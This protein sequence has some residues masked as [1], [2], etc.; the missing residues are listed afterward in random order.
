MTNLSTET[1]TENIPGTPK[2]FEISDWVV[3]FFALFSGLVTIVFFV[4]GLA[5]GSWQ[6]IVLAGI[7]VLIG[8]ISLIAQLQLPRISNE[9]KIL[10]LA[11][12][13]EIAFIVTANF[14]AQSW[15]PLAIVS[16]VFAILVSSVGLKGRL[17]NIGLIAGL[18]SALI[19][20]L[21]GNFNTASQISS[22]AAIIFFYTI[23]AILLGIYVVLILTRQALV[24]LRIK[25]VTIF[26]AITLI[27]LI[28]I[29]IIQSI[30][31]QN[32]I[33][34]QA[35]T[36][37]RLA[38]QQVAAEID[39]FFNSNVDSISKEASLKV[40]PN[41]INLPSADRA[42]SQ[43]ETDLNSTV[44]SL[45]IKSTGFT[46]SYGILNP[47]GV[48]IYDTN[49]LQIGA[50]EGNADYFLQ[51]TLTGLAYASPVE[52]NP[53]N[54]DSYIYFSA[55]IRNE[56]LNVIGV[57]RIRYDAL[58]LQS[59]LKKYISL[60]GQRSYPILLDEYFIRLGDAMTPSLLYKSITPLN[61]TQISNL[62]VSRR[63]PS[64]T[65][66]Q[67]ST[68]LPELEVALRDAITNPYFVAEL[69]PND[70]NHKE[71]GAIIR[72]TSQPWYL[73]FVEEQSIIDQVRVQQLRTSS[74]IATLIAG[75]IGIIGMVVSTF[76]SNPIL[77]LTSVAEKI[78]GG[79]MEA[80]AVIHTRDEIETLG[81]TFN[82]M[83][84]QLKGFIT[85]LEDRVRDRTKQLAEQ[86][87]RL[88]FRSRQLQ[89]V[90][91]VARGIAQTQALETLL[92]T[93]V[94]L[95]SNR[96][97]FYHVGI[98]LLDNQKQYA[99]LRAANS[100]GGK[101]MLARQHR[102]EVG[103]VGIVGYVTGAG[104]PRIATDVGKD[105]VY[106]SNPD[107]PQTR[108]EMALP[109]SAGGNVIGALDVQS[110][111]S[112]AF[113]QEDI[114]LF[115]TLAD[116]ISIA[117]INN[118]LYEETRKALEDAQN[119][120]RQ[121]LQ[122]EW[123]KELDEHAFPSYVFTQQGVIA[124]ERD[125]SPEVQKAIKSGEIVII[126]PS[127]NAPENEPY[128]MV[129]PIKIRGEVIGAIRLKESMAIIKGWTEEEI[130]TISNVAEQVG[131]ALE[132]ARL[133]EQTVRRA[134]RERKVLEISSKIRST[135]DTQQM[136]KIAM[137]ELQRSA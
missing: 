116:Q 38:A 123:V 45:R 115:A 72:L 25:L 10:G 81:N 19:T 32:A 50:R 16:L 21:T 5:T 79:D 1:K 43:E 48:N 37:L 107:L 71:A 33:Q 110:V 68:D 49:P 87:E 82:L 103:Q 101:R 13:L 55:P 31:L 66:N 75:L 3:R 41:Y 12:A 121:Y 124:S 135:T 60:I 39:T 133:F 94:T 97:N 78:A 34:Q 40:F 73:V 47:L 11:L 128:G 113:T 63:L 100:D 126:P 27:P 58:V 74:L 108:S 118:Q 69:H 61:S 2:R 83:T 54:G 136:I 24:S 117:L 90:S 111:E 91:D 65:E 92:N 14:I 119:L 56:Q 106:F 129:V 96:F 109:L 52:F 95:I 26:L 53:L 20:S 59:I 17:S 62:Q 30:I 36:A 35:N 51:P 132:T 4:I 28:L 89:T 57:L 9:I 8:I 131:L 15:I 88:V 29:S 44:N 77:S 98:F 84:G 127:K 105:A 70:K 112:N 102:L 122:Q 18:A 67:L 114:E 23:F 22:Q 76:I 137:E 64:S 6:P 104:K 46:P 42:S 120:H 7:F 85:Q 134:D 86:N 125:R 130:T 80:Q 93:I 99:V